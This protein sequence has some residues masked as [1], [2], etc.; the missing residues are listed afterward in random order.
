MIIDEYGLSPLQEGMLFHHLSGDVP[1]VDIEQIV[2]GYG[3]P[4]DAELLERAW[5]LAVERHA[6]LRTS[7]EWKQ[8][9]VPMQQVHDHIELRL[10]VR[11]G[12][13]DEAGFQEFLAHDRARGFDLSQAPLMRLLLFDYGQH[14][15]RLVW[16][17][18]HILLDG[19]AFILVLNDVEE[20]YQ[21]LLSGEPVAAEPG[22]AFHPYIEWLQSLD[23][24]G[25]KQFWADRLRGLAGP[26][27]LLEDAQ[28]PGAVWAEWLSRARARQGP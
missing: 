2:I 17:V 15:Y 28:A 18:H 22:P 5:R 8:H 13:E 11:A 3:E 12:A 19:R 1:G 4:V 16:T 14:R 25:A 27:P 26:T 9:S 20:F 21:R 7:F 10:E 24:E 6:A 23:L